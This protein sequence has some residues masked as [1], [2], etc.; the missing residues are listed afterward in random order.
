MKAQQKN[1][2]KTVIGFTHYQAVNF[3]REGLRITAVSRFVA[4]FFNEF[5]I[6]EQF[7]IWNSS[8]AAVYSSVIANFMLDR[9]FRLCQKAIKNRDAIK[10]TAWTR[11]TSRFAKTLSFR[12]FY[13]PVRQFLIRASK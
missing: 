7:E 6:R 9:I 11:S 4:I 12:K 1:N 3:F 10:K 2:E 8:R 5:A 13:S